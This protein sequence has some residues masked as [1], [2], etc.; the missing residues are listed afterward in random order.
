MSNYREFF[1][2]IT[3]TYLFLKSGAL[4]SQKTGHVISKN[5]VAL[6]QPAVLIYLF[7]LNLFKN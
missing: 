4:I 3:K 6:C 7:R 1:K 2:V 5:L